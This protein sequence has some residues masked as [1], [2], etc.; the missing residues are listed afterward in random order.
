VHC[1]RANVIFV[2]ILMGSCV[3]SIE[4]G[5]YSD[6]TGFSFT[7]P[8]DWVAAARPGNEINNKTKPD[9]KEWL[10]KNKIDLSK[11]SMVLIHNTKEE[12]KENINVDV[13]S[14]Q[15]QVD[16]EGLKEL[17]D[18]LTKQ[19]K[20][21]GV[22]VENVDK[23][24]RKIGAN[25]VIVIEYQFTM[26]QLKYPLKQKQVFFPGGGKT[27]IVCCTAKADAFAD[28]SQTFDAILSSFQ[29]PPLQ[30]QK[31]DWNKVTFYG[32]IMVGVVAVL[33]VF[34]MKITSNKKQRASS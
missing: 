14:G 4:G 10:D 30:S 17:W 27:Y 7:Y 22:A 23:K 29:V 6:P 13:E 9:I 24:V 11:L 32:G 31:Y 21:I 25:D 34:L 28:Q 20:S 15:I 18:I 1:S 5:E 2:M 16:D 3:S 8:D 26:P 19:Y 12:Y 33:I